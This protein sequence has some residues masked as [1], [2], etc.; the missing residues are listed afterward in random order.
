MRAQAGNVWI[1]DAQNRQLALKVRG[2]PEDGPLK[3]LAD[4]VL[5][6][7]AYRTA[8][9]KMPVISFPEE[10]AVDQPLKLISLISVPIE[11]DPRNWAVVLVARPA[12]ARPYVREDVH[13]LQTLCVY[14][15]VYFAQYQ[16]RE[17]RALAQRLGKLAEIEA[18][19]AGTTELEKM[20]FVLANRSRELMS[21]DRVFV[22]LPKGSSWQV[23][24]VSG[25]DDVQQQG[26]V[27]QNL[28]DL[29][30][31]V[32][33]I[34]GDWHFTPAY[35]EKVED[36]ELRA[37]LGEYFA[38]SE[39]KSVL[40]MRVADDAGLEGI[41]GFERRAE[42]GYSKPD[43]QFLQ[44]YAKVCARP[45]RRARAFQCLPAI[46]IVKRASALKAAAMGPRR[47]R[48]FLKVGLAA[49]VLALLVFGR[50]N[51]SIRGDGKV[52]PYLQT[53]AAP[54]IDGVVKE[55]LKTEHD[56]VGKGDV[57]A[58]L[59]DKD[60]QLR[61][62]DAR[63]RIGEHQAR[64]D[65]L[66]GTDT[67]EWNVELKRLAVAQNELSMLE[68]DLE[69]IN[70]TSPQDGVIITRRDEINASLDAVRRAG[71]PIA[72]VADF[73]K[74]Y[75]EA[76]IA[77]RDIRFVETGQRIEFLLKGAPGD[78]HTVEID[79]ISPT[80]KP[81][82][83]KNVFVARG[84]IDNSDGRFKPGHGGAARIYVGSK[85]LYYVIFRRTIEWVYTQL[86][87]L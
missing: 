50:W 69:G 22:A 15:S 16:L 67:A 86:Q 24:A 27:V 10:G 65:Q 42:S 37:R 72:V 3:E 61:V 84:L 44:G 55:I 9:Q 45:L 52:E 82:A 66:R 21:F 76:Y 36:E 31:E 63:L 40:F 58:V 5:S 47:H 83:G 35:L 39:F 20:A 60:I 48:L 74:V 13:T 26:A 41:V 54:R 29:A 12:T 38:V 71:D 51:L 33:R 34:G 75:I 25:V 28:R 23:A 77:E 8:E 79:S 11:I 64:I 73:S 85:P 49:A 2:I 4:D 62:Q 19:L 81:V 70:V 53:Y 30:R 32:A 6:N 80:T 87:L 18:D 7:V 78:V 43:F 46:G 59:D 57:I 14:L 17:T 56:A 1:Y 68:H